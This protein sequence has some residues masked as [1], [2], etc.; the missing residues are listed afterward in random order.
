MTNAEL[1]SIADASYNLRAMPIILIN[2]GLNKR[3]LR[4]QG[5]LRSCHCFD[6]CGAWSPVSIPSNVRWSTTQSLVTCGRFGQI[7]SVATLAV[8]AISLAFSGD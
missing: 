8:Q 3:S 5:P 4:G 2:Q 7:A 1:V 6:K